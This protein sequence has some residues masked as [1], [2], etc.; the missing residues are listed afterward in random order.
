MKT[1]QKHTPKNITFIGKPNAK[2]EW[3][4]TLGDNETPFV[5]YPLTVNCSNDLRQTQ[6]LLVGRAKKAFETVFPIWEKNINILIKEKFPQW[7]IGDYKLALVWLNM[8]ENI[9]I[10]FFTIQ[11]PQ[12]KVEEN[13]HYGLLKYSYHCQMVRLNCDFLQN[14]CEEREDRGECDYIFDFLAHCSGNLAHIANSA[15]IKL[16]PQSDFDDN[17]LPF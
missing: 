4:K 5:E 8:G 11:E 10:P 7:A 3:H 2:S 13:T 12:P 15:M 1:T 6:N 16:I 9:N 14:E 17:D